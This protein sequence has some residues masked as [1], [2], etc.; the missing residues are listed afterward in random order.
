MLYLLCW[1]RVNPV[2]LKT[3]FE[4]FLV[5]QSSRQVREIW[6]VYLLCWLRVNPGILKTYSEPFLI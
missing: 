3:Y 2:I 1:L 4:P 6:F 5:Q